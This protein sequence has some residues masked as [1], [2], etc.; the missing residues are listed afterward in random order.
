M[1]RYYPDHPTPHQVEVIRGRL[2][3]QWACIAREWE[4]RETGREWSIDEAWEPDR[5]PEAVL[6]IL[7][8]AL[9]WRKL[10][11]LPAFDPADHA[12]FLAVWER[13]D[14][15]YWTLSREGAQ[16]LGV[17]P[18]GLNARRRSR[19]IEMGL[20]DAIGDILT[21]DRALM[22][23]GDGESRWLPVLYLADPKRGIDGPSMPLF[24]WSRS[25]D[26]RESL[27]DIQHIGGQ[28]MASLDEIGP[29]N[30]PAEWCEDERARMFT[31]ESVR[32]R[33]RAGEALRQAAG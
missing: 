23:V 13:P 17:V 30:L 2:A 10:P 27:A 20:T 15:V 26:P 25:I 7:E 12:A 21:G 22:P 29:D 5:K 6:A 33:D 4:C 14:G 3:R 16:K 1:G 19:A 8:W 32:L 31:R 9:A 11:M 18:V 24:R 28:Q